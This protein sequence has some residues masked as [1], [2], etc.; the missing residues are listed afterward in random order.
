MAQ[1]KYRNNW[2]IKDSGIQTVI[3]RNKLLKL[4]PILW[5]RTIHDMVLCPASS[6]GFSLER[7]FGNLEEKRG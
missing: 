2:F 1:N 6:L 3:R 5:F 4:R 7:H